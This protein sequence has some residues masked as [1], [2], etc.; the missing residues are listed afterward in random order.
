[1]RWY[2]PERLIYLQFSGQVTKE[3]VIVAVHSMV[4]VLQFDPRKYIIVDASLVD[5]YPT[6]VELRNILQQLHYQPTP[7]W[8]VTYGFVK[9]IGM[10]LMSFVAQMMGGALPCGARFRRIAQVSATGR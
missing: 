1:M 8:V 6:L 2:A 9:G 3:E 10:F 5:R 7:T 4:D